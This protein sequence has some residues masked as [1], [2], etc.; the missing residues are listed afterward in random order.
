V[1]SAA[2]PNRRSVVSF[3]TKLLAAMMLVISGLTGLSLYLG[4]RSI[5]ANVERELQQN[6]Q[7]ELSALHEVQELRH[8]AL[9]ERCGTLVANPRI[10][11]ALEDNALDLL[12]P[13][14]KDELR[15]LM[16]G[17][18]PSSEREA[19]SLHARFYRF[20][21][22]SGVVLSPPN[23][24]DVGELDRDA[25]GQLALGK[26][27]QTLQSGYL[28]ETAA[29]VEKNVDEVMAVPIFSTE[30]GDVISALVVG[31]KPFEVLGKRSGS[32][33]KS[34]IWTNGFLY[35]AALSKSARAAI[36]SEISDKVRSYGQAHNSFVTHVDGAPHLL[37]YKR[38]NPDSL[39][40]P[41]YEIC[42]Y[43][44]AKSIARQNRLRWQIS[45]A[46]A[47]LLLGGFMA[48][49]FIAVRLAGPVE[50]LAI[51][52]EENRAQRER[53]EAALESTSEELERTARYS[54]DASHQLKSPV[55][56]LRAGIEALLAREDFKPEV[57]EELSGLLHQTH[58]LTGVIDDLLLLSRLDAGHLQIQSEQVNLSELVDEWLDDLSALSDSPDI[59]IEKEYPAD[60]CVA[61]EKQYTSLIVQNLLENARKYNRTGGRIRVA[62]RQT[63]AEV[64]LAIGNTGRPIA[65][66]TQ[67]HIFERFH[68]GSIRS[69]VS[70]HGL[71]LNLARELARLHG[72]DLRLLRSEKDWTEFEVRFHG[73]VRMPRP[74]G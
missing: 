23:P 59:H 25:E 34:G 13:S 21:D 46:G 69:E 32:G 2:D 7:A 65:Q 73:A 20:L 66:A 17:E 54:A 43:P 58:R 57:Y 48:S 24:K 72:G 19:R 74:P 47:F 16:E 61:G 33:I 70:G 64:V 63:H 31:F 4:Q 29:S 35:L 14:A 52:S 62:A 68:R 49:R 15:D 22:E 53:A 42:I 38:L 28:S 45:G 39:F 40:P 8:A 67:R 56:V 6:F 51:D 41:A 44:L 27:P 71:G 11:A 60:L 18:E 10:H 12:Y 1:I 30:T 5:A 9:I 36:A 3:R 37:F 55:S 26:L 50:K